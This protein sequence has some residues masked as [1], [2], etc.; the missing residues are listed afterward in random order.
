M[1]HKI[2]GDRCTGPIEEIGLVVMPAFCFTFLVANSVIICVKDSTGD[3]MCNFGE[4]AEV[5]ECVP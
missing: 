5:S 4:A 1:Y 2:I 3:S